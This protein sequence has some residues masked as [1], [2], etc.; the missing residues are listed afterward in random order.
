MHT[1]GNL[2]PGDGVGSRRSFRTPTQKLTVVKP[3]CYQVT[4][5][6]SRISPNKTPEKSYFNI[7]VSRWQAFQT[8]R[9]LSCSLLQTFVVITTAQQLVRNIF[10]GW[11]YFYQPMRI[12][13]SRATVNK[14]QDGDGGKFKMLCTRDG[15]TARASSKLEPKMAS[16]HS[17]APAPKKNSRAKKLGSGSK[18]EN[19]SQ[20]A[21][22]WL[23][24][25]TNQSQKLGS[26]SRIFLRLDLQ[27]PKCYI[28]NVCVIFNHYQS[29]TLV[30]SVEHSNITKAL[31]W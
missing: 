14:K 7:F 25:K 22:L 9:H 5:L 26:G 3:R 21:Q 10:I 6:T 8:F 28:G 23:Q 29:I 16:F 4:R 31:H 20:K 30:I 27:W 19:Q 1:G 2:T 24:N 13:P 12:M 15:Q 11:L 18:I 17:S